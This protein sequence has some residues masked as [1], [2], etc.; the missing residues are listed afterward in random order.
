M[1]SKQRDGITAF[2]FNIKIFAQQM[3]RAAGF[4]D[5]LSLSELD[6]KLT[7]I[8]HET[9]CAKAFIAKIRTERRTTRTY[10]VG[11]RFIERHETDGQAFESAQAYTDGP[12][13]E[14]L[15]RK[16]GPRWYAWSADD[17]QWIHSETGDR[18]P[19]DD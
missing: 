6:A 10:R 12:S 8:A 15:E 9:K 19:A 14:K 3:E 1:T 11:G 16:F 2:A 18:L 5:L 7:Q 13:V 17:E 4:V